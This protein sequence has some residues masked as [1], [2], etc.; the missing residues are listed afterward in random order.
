MLN[1]L[2]TYTG[3]TTLTATGTL[4]STGTT[5][6]GILVGTDV[7]PN[8]AGALGVSDTPL[9]INIGDD[10]ANIVGVGLS[11][12]VTFGRDILV[13]IPTD[14]H[15]VS[16]F[17]NTLYTARVTGGIG[18]V[19]GGTNRV[20]QL[21]ALN[22]GRLELRGPIS[23]SAATFVRVG[24][25]AN[26]AAR[27]GVVYFGA[28][29][30]GYSPNT[31]TGSTFL[32]NARIVIGADALY[33]GSSNSLTI[34]SGPFGSSSVLFGAGTN[35][36]GTFLGADGT[37]RI[38]PN[39]LA[40]MSTDANLAVTF[41]G[42]GN[43]TFINTNNAG[44]GGAFNLH[45][46]ATLRNRTFAVNTTQ[47]AIQFDAN[48]I[49]SGTNGANLFKTGSGILTITG[50]N[51]AFNKKT[52][53]GN[54]GTSWFIT[55]GTL[56]VTGDAN[57]GDTTVIAAGTAG[58]IA[59]GLP[60]DV[61][62]GGGVLSV[63]GTFS[64]AHQFILTAASGVEVSGAN[65]FTQALPLVGAFGVTKLG[66]GTLALNSTN[67]NNSLTVGNFV[68]GGG[69]VRTT[70]TTG[71]PF[72][73][74][75]VTLNGGGLLVQGTVGTAPGGVNSGTAQTAASLILNVGSSAGIVPGM[76]IS[77]TNIAA[78]TVVT[79]VNGNNITLS[80]LPTAAVAAATPLTFGVQATALVVPTLNY[81]GAGSLQ[82]VQ[83]TGVTNTFTATALTRQT[84]GM[85]TV[86]STDLSADLGVNEK[87]LTSTAQTTTSGILAAPTVVGR[88]AAGQD[89]NFLRYDN[90]NGF[91]LHNATLATDLTVSA[92]TSLGDFSAVQQ[93]A[94]GTIDV[95][96]L[97]T[98]ANITPF[99]STSLLRLA[100]GGLIMNGPTAAVISGN[101]RFGTGGAA[102]EALV[103]IGGGQTGD[104]TISGNFEAT[105]FTKA[106]AGTLLLSG[107]GNVMAP[108][109]T[110][111]RTL[112]VQE[113]TLK[114]SSQSAV[115]SGGLL[116]I[117][118]NNAGV[119]DL[120]GQN[121]SVAGLTGSGAVINSGAASVLTVD[122]GVGQNLTYTGT[123]G[124]NLGLTKFGSGALTLNQPINADGLPLANTYTGET[125]IGTGRVTAAVAITPSAL[126]TLSI[127]NTLALGTGAI[128]LQG[129]TLDMAAVAPYAGGEVWGG[130]NT[131][132][133]GPGNGYNITVDALNS[134][135]SPNTTSTLSVAVTPVAWIKINDVVMNAPTITFAGSS[136]NYLINGTFDLSANPASSV[137]INGLSANAALI[138]GRV[139]AAGKT[140]V[141]IGTGTTYL[142]NG[143]S[144]A[145]AN[146]V[147][148][149]NIALGRI[150]A[151]LSN[152]GSNPLG[153]G[154]A[155]TLNGGGLNI[156]HDGDNTT[157]MQVLTTFQSNDVVIGST[158][159]LGSQSYLGSANSVISVDR[160]NGGSN[161]TI[162]F[163]DLTFGGSLATAFLTVNAGNGHTVSFD[164]L[165]MTKDAYLAID[166]SVTI[167][168]PITGNGTL[169]KQNGGALFVNADNAATHRGGTVV[170]GGT[171][172]FGTFEGNVLALS[173]T[174][175]SVPGLVAT[176]NLGTGNILVNPGSAI[177]FNSTSNLA[178]G[179]TGILD[180]RSNV[181]GTRGILRMA[182][183]APLSD[184]HLRVGSLGGP[185]TSGFFSLAGG[186]GLDGVG[187]SGGGI[188]VALNTVYTQTIDLAR[189]GD[190]TAFLGS[191]TNG[192]GLNGSYNAATLGPGAGQSFRL[193]AGGSTLYVSS[194]MANNNVLTDLGSDPAAATSL[195]VG[196]PHSGLNVDTI[197]AA[198]GR[199]T[200]VLMTDNDY[201]GSTTVNRGSVL[202]FRGS[203]NTSAFDTW[204]TLIAGGL[205][206]TF[207]DAAGTAP[208][209]PVTL[210][211]TSE[212]RFDYA[213]G[214][215][216]TAKL[217]GYGGQGRWDD[218]TPITLTNATLRLQ[219]NRDIE[220][221]ETVGDVTLRHF[222]QFVVQRD[223]VNRRVTMVVGNG[224][225]ADLVRTVDLNVN[226]LAISGNNATLQINPV[227]GGQLGSDERVL[228][229]GGVAAI[230]GGITNG[231]VAPWMINATDFQFLTYTTANGFV[232]AGFTGIRTGN[233]AAAGQIL[234]PTERTIT[235]AALTF[236]AAGLGV[237]LDTYALRL[238]TGDIAFG[239]G[240]TAAATDRIRIRSGG[241]IVNGART[242]AP[243]IEFGLS[244]S[245]TTEAAVFNNNNLLIGV[246]ATAGSTTGQITNASQFVKHGGG[247]LFI[248]A[249]Q[250]SFSGNWI[251]NQGSI[252][253]R[254]NTVQSNIGGAATDVNR[255]AGTGGWVV[256]NS[257]SGSL[258]L[259][260]DVASTVFN[261]GLA[262]GE[263][264][265]Q[266]QLLADRSAGTASSVLVQLGGGIRFGGSAGEQ[267]QT[268][269][270]S[271]GNSYTHQINGGVDFGPGTLEGSQAFAFIRNDVN[272][273]VRGKLTGGGTFVKA[274]GSQIDFNSAALGGVNDNTGG[275]QIVQ[276]TLVF[277]ATS[278]GTAVSAFPTVNSVLS[279]GGIGNGSMTLWGGALNLLY[280]ATGTT[281]TAR[282]KF[283]VG[284]NA[285]G[286][287]LI[288]NGSTTINVDRNGGTTTTKHLA[289]K[290]LTIGS[291]TLGVTGANAYVLEINGGTNLVGTPTLNV[292]T[293]ELLLN[294]AV[295][296]GGSRQAIVKNGGQSLWLN[297]STSSFGGLYAGTVGT[298]G[299]G[300]VVNG[301][302]LRFGNIGTENAS[303][304]NVASILNNSTVRINPTGNMYLT[305]PANI[306][307]GLGQVQL[308]GSGVQLPVLR[309]ANSGFTQAY[310]QNAVSSDSEG[311]IGIDATM[312]NNLDLGLIG[313]G[314]S[315][316]AA[317][318]A[319]RSYTAAALGVGAGNIYRIGG[320]GLYDHVELPGPRECGCARG[321]P[322]PRH[323]ARRRRPVGQPE[324][325]H[326]QLRPLHLHRRHGRQPQFLAGHPRNLDRHDGPARHRR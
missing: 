77:G 110:A 34:V 118:V 107:T 159:G 224:G 74:G 47:G 292:S 105:D 84:G 174:A 38:I 178:A 136:N 52:D 50:T 192:I 72:G 129:G 176:S 83:G 162:R 170:N 229:A 311:V 5:F 198:N 205:G 24:D 98:S 78:N 79:A 148:G 265:L 6:A 277:R 305:N 274:G 108:T 209:A 244:G 222:S 29:A 297:D 36:G 179:W 275:I 76:T 19:G 94:A 321:E 155:I 242:I 90:T 32:D 134:F 293:A 124:G 1:G 142:T 82:L 128:R 318:G 237:G 191:T 200:V 56:R 126:G 298:F 96:A 219:G 48:F 211:S 251:I 238:E 199:G 235:N 106:G 63:G 190:G 140:I 116:N 26:P 165:T 228:L 269:F 296:D 304:M 111:F 232:N 215:L 87:F 88:T 51:S 245:G 3:T 154:A 59:T 146:V 172:F 241:L 208:L 300:I 212:L 316:L 13:Q 157:A 240:V 17:G 121:L 49:S 99:D 273:T 252:F 127:R 27:S 230:P 302:L 122:A 288:V 314:K 161:K 233:I 272:A 169:Y 284:N 312:A 247:S 93:V 206:G 182:A 301:G 266:A 218:D 173:D 256:M 91:M 195:I 259:R 185:Q 150:E 268:L 42:R 54:Y 319:A 62:L 114:F 67:A 239:T 203:L 135:G 287:S 153:A 249:I 70:M 73:T 250:P 226:G 257:F 163:G 216:A 201:S 207:V 85:L 112:T 123:L 270:I 187:K 33:S 289:F 193:G 64:T 65:T 45:S 117:A 57:L 81:A 8:T 164:G 12:Q 60:T 236:N 307:F 55:A 9:L 197:A 262:I 243:G 100:N 7:L 20:L 217:E 95:L 103:W 183:N 253:L 120:N 35:N 97:R 147:G 248:D 225:A 202:E 4:P 21:Q 255:A 18:I 89:L 181:M 213:T 223:L 43:L 37:N 184:F 144:G 214:L 290:D 310:I 80:L 324:R 58:H 46:G 177:Q 204:G 186:A 31:Y 151:R 280:N 145:G 234:V 41:E 317:T 139:S 44:T 175:G 295:T 69:T 16:I 156:R 210:R 130:L 23:S 313:N 14:S 271:A 22:T 71:T 166:P 282:E 323:E 104:A 278:P 180:V 137:V 86:I 194:D 286:N 283:W 279:Q 131:I 11:G 171:V 299:L 325:R 25:V 119:W 168:G 102:Q 306:A 133:F 267:G 138:N 143:E 281:V 92:A 189:I 40:T 276:G 220:I 28:A 39:A 141:K 291:S 2:N 263:G 10:T 53:D 246:L 196:M 115:P 309:L 285:S 260:A 326:R 167:N 254:S 264:N 61:R 227:N 113:G 308:N 68:G 66:S 30:N 221:T 75:A 294:G 15:N 149:W 258:N 152:N 303:V 261:V 160:L 315:Y 132:Q 322:D 109:V 101:L 320:G 231:M 125:I 188:I 158:I